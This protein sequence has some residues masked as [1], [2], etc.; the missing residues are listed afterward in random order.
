[1]GWREGK[2]ERRRE[3]EEERG[4]EGGRKEKEK[5]SFVAAPSM[6]TQLSPPMTIVI[7]S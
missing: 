6:Q 1:M 7:S 4:R 5:D 2:G 3:R